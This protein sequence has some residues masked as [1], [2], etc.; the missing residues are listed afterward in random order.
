M[1]VARADRRHHFGKPGRLGMLV[2][3]LLPRLGLIGFLGGGRF[4]GGRAEGGPDGRGAA[5]GRA[6]AVGGAT[7]VEGDDFGRGAF[8]AFGS[9]SQS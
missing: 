9:N 1:S 7:D 8:L 4:G 3:R 6:G 2:E 5:P